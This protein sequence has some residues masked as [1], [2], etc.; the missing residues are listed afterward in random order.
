MKSASPQYQLS[1]VWVNYLNLQ[2][3]SLSYTAIGIYVC[4]TTNKLKEFTLEDLALASNP[5]ILPEIEF[6]VEE[7]MSAGLIELMPAAVVQGGAS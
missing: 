7:L 6:A 1:K 3:L 5:N 4:A 2:Q